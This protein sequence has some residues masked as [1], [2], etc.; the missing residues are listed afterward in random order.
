[1]LKS[2]VFFKLRP[3]GKGPTFLDTAGILKITPSS[4]YAG[5]RR[6][7]SEV[8][9]LG[10]VVVLADEWWTL[11]ITEGKKTATLLSSERWCKC[12]MEMVDSV[13]RD[14][15]RQEGLV[16]LGRR[17]WFRVSTKYPAVGYFRGTVGVLNQNKQK[18]KA[19]LT[20]ICCTELICRQYGM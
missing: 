5:Y 14:V 7:E 4:G 19:F 9:W 18:E 2:H 12:V 3:N 11:H 17:I 13:W 20:V 8:R 10:H 15:Q 16:M 6:G 1:M